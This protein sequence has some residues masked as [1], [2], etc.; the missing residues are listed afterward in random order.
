MNLLRK[1]LSPLSSLYG[2]VTST[3][4]TLYDKGILKSTVFKIP[5]IV[6]G[7]LSVGGTGKTPMVEYLV[8]LLQSKHKLAILS[9]G[10]KRR[11]TG[12]LLADPASTADTLGDEPMQYYTKFKDI[13]VAVDADRVNGINQLL[14]LSDAPDVVLLDD[15]FQHRK[16]EAGFNI[17]LTSYNDL[18]VD[19]KMLP[20]GNLREKVEGAQRA[21]LIVVTKC[22]ATLS[23]EE[24]FQITKKL[25]V[26]LHQ[27]V[28]FSKIKYEAKVYN[29]TSSI[30]LEELLDYEIMLVTGIANPQ[31]LC[32]FFKGKKIQFKHLA[33]DDHH[34]FT[35]KDMS[36]IRKMYEG[37][38]ADKKLLITTEKDYIRS[39]RHVK[40]DFYF[41]PIQTEFIDHQDDFNTIIVNYVEQNS[42]DSSLYK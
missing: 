18:Y 42:R 10:Y 19:D 30:S 4:N 6:V 5:I 7:N 23:E 37:I 17:L 36:R 22:P 32:D 28:F 3:R 26:D 2:K 1:I 14:N 33:F 8:R 20:A 35:E 41:L 13:K 9:R 31:P 39:F 34:N 29:P 21:Q 16:V 27:T 12:F 11:S 40:D 25:N 15:A 38:T 24:Q